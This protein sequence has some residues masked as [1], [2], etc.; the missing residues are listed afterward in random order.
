MKQLLKEPCAKACNIESLSLE[1]KNAVKGKAI[2]NKMTA[3]LGKIGRVK[4]TFKLLN[5]IIFIFPRQGKE[6]ELLNE[7]VHTQ[8][9]N[10]YQSKQITPT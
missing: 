3:F 5:E 1:E 6:F 2:A 9:H 10:I 7:L 4:R 8:S